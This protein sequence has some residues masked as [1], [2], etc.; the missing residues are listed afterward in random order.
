MSGQRSLLKPSEISKLVHKMAT[1]ILAACESTADLAIV[2]IRTRGEFLAQRLVRSILKETGVECPMGLLDVSF[3]RD[4][5]RAR[6]KQPIVQQTLIPFDITDKHIVLVDDVLYT[7]RSVR[8]ALDEIM[9]FGRPA[10][11]R[12][13]VLIDRGHRELPIQP[14]FVGMMVPTSGSEL[15]HVR[16]VENDGCDEVVV[17]TLD[18][19]LS[20]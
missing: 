6:L 20:R 3:Y 8:A 14:D 1:D 19:P 11:V 12:L 2:G 17:T 18:D 16:L 5:T 13:A 10:S 7:G 9:D 4:D 15:V